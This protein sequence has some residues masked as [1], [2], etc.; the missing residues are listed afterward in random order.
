MTYHIHTDSSFRNGFSNYTPCL[1]VHWSLCLFFLFW[2]HSPNFVMATKKSS[3]LEY[4]NI[5][6]SHSPLYE[7]VVDFV[8]RTRI[9]KTKKK[10]N[11]KERQ[12]ENMNERMNNE[13]K[14]ENEKRKKLF[15]VVISLSLFL[16][17][18]IFR[19]LSSSNPISKQNWPE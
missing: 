16:S 18:S 17:S 7:Q 8:Q 4:R 9:A 2:Y 5:L 13:T 12:E 1:P 3:Y 6:T 15:Y 19:R 14:N 10:M 11:K